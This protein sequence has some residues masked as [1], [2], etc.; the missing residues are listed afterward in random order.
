MEHTR[1]WQR[2]QPDLPMTSPPKTKRYQL[3]LSDGK[4]YRSKDCMFSARSPPAP[5][6]A[7]PLAASRL[8][9]ALWRAVPPPPLLRLMPRSAL[10]R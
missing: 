5:I 6:A 1:A 9:A 10:W 2:G 3:S 8:A 4:I 7:A